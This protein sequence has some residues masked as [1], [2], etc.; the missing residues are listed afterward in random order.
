MQPLDH[1]AIAGVGEFEE[2]R[3]ERA[4]DA[5]RHRHPPGIEAQEMPAGDGAAERPGVARR[6]KA[7]GFVGVAGGA[8]DP[9]HHLA[10]GDKGG[11]QRPPAQPLLL[12][13]GQGRRQ[14]G[15]AR[16]HPGPGPGQAVELEGVRQG[17]VGQCRRRCADRRPARAENMAAAARPGAPGIADD[18]P[19][20][21]QRRA[22]DD[23]RHRIG[24]ARLGPA[25][26]RGRNILVAQPRR[27]AGE[28]NRLLGHACLPEHLCDP[29]D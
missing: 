2:P 5:E 24:D 12:G 18:D 6:M 17:A 8:A 21:R 4:G 1:A 29:E 27:I 26:D 9:H 7:A 23:R 19:A 15:G 20:P 16:M 11:D 13:D 3:G 22:A 25:D 14:Q 28:P 10:A